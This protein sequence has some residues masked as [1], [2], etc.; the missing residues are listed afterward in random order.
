MK[1]NSMLWKVLVAIFLAVIVGNLTGTTV[2]IFGLPFYQIF[3]TIGELFVNS[4]TL[5][6][7][8]L[9]A[10]AIIS[11]IGQMSG[12]QSFKSLGLKTFLFY[13]MT[14]ALAVVVGVILVN[15]IHPGSFH[16]ELTQTLTSPTNI[17]ITSQKEAFTGV[18]FKLIPTNIIA[19][20]S[21]G[22]MLGIIFFSLLFGFSMIH[23]EKEPHGILLNFWKGMLATLLRMTHFVMKAMPFGVFCLMA[24]VVASQGIQSIS[25]LAYFFLTV[26]GGLVVFCFV[27]LPL[28][29]RFFG[30]NPI[31]HLKAVTPALFT[32]FSTS[33]SAATLP[34]TIECVEKNAGVSNRICS[35]VVPL[36]TS[37]NMAGSALYECVAVL[38]I[39]QAYGIDLTI[40]HQILIAV[41]SLITSM[42]VAGIPSGSLV[43]IIIILNTLGLPAE[44]IALILPV[45]RLLDMCRTTAN[46][47]S[48]TTCAVLV[49]KSEGETVLTS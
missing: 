40:G 34:A 45:D 9:I 36:G 26:F 42:G 30:L 29:L 49:A 12:Q 19:A 39:A 27:V 7:V 13:I 47:F 43:A 28:L 21:S 3:D 16:Q 8:P 11:G 4:L 46:V 15:V 14:I 20:A 17:Q 2:G 5:L 31:T 35:F 38:F 32:A 37:M 10:S 6:S 18:L 41:L 24:K 1:K 48:D 25:N 23:I 22:N 44:G 33:S